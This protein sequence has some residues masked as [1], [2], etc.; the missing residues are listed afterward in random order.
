MAVVAIAC[1]SF[2]I[3]LIRDMAGEMRT[4]HGTMARE[5]T[6]CQGDGHGDV[7]L[8]SVRWCGEP[9]HGIGLP[10]WASLALGGRV[11]LLP[12][13]PLTGHAA[14]LRTGS[15]RRMASASP[16]TGRVEGL[17]VP[18][19]PRLCRRWP[20]CMLGGRAPVP[21]PSRG[22]F[23]HQ[24]TTG[25]S[26]GYAGALARHCQTDDLLPDT[27]WARESLLRYD[28]RW[29]KKIPHALRP[30]VSSAR[31]YLVCLSSIAYIDHLVWNGHREEVTR[32]P[33]CESRTR[34]MRGGICYHLSA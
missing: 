20:A 13:P 23:S 3:A 33:P 1:A 24:R 32:G 7:P 12:I 21:A 29:G 27:D 31:N 10:G 18:P 2:L 17:R 28:T 15:A 9:P 8:G 22:A 11:T 19:R 26:A 14:I 30:T 4:C 16:C 34:A 6:R 25:R 5:C